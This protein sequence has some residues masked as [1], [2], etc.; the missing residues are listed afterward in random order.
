MQIKWFQIPFKKWDTFDINIKWDKYIHLWKLTIIESKFKTYI[1]YNP[2]RKEKW[3]A[4]RIHNNF[5]IAK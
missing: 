5:F 4:T 2:K 1:I 3:I